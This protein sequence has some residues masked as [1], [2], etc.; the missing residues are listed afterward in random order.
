MNPKKRKDFLNELYAAQESLRHD[1]SQNKATVATVS[2]EE[3][4]RQAP[5]LF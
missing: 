3:A 5:N 4:K 1:N 2:L